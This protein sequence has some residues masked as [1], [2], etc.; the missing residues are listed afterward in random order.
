MRAREILRLREFVM[1]MHIL[2][3]PL[4]RIS[5]RILRDVDTYTKIF[6]RLVKALVVE[7]DNGYIGGDYCHEF[8]CGT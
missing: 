8:V 4:K 6:E 5:K 3:M 7:S 2:S 1:K